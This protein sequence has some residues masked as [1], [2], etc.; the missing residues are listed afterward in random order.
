[1]TDAYWA[2]E[3]VH[4]ARFETDSETH[5]RPHD[6]FSLGCVF[7]LLATLRIFR[8]TS[9]GI[10]EFQRLRESSI[11]SGSR[12]TINGKAHAFH[13]TMNVVRE[14]MD[15]LRQAAPRDDRD[16]ISLILDLIAEMLQVRGERLY[17]WEVVI[18][19]RAILDPEWLASATKEEIKTLV[20]P[21]RTLDSEIMHNPFKRA[22]RKEW[23]S[24]VLDALK[25]TKW[26][27]QVPG[28]TEELKRRKRKVA[29]YHSTLPPVPYD[30][31]FGF[32][33]L[34]KVIAETFA[35]KANSVALFGLGGMG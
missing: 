17:S 6:V 26:Y 18:S 22:D 19:L 12:N 10:E 27:I 1:M 30:K 33:K 11:Q 35:T 14:W 31:L 20:Q 28:S 16:K 5:G 9:D 32:H 25:E 8:W 34:N 23:P 15:H 29:R 3:E 4:E 7:L 24:P 21:S 13:N 2:P